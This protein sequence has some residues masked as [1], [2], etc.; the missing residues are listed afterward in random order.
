MATMSANHAP[1]GATAPEPV[2]TEPVPATPAPGAPMPEPVVEA[3]ETVAMDV[4]STS[5]TSG[6]GQVVDTIRA[7]VSKVLDAGARLGSLAWFYRRT[8]VLIFLAIVFLVLLI[9]VV[10][11]LRS[12]AVT[13]AW[14]EVGSTTSCGFDTRGA[15]RC[16]PRD[17]AIVPV[18]RHIPTRKALAALT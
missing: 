14:R 13:E 11:V 2:A 15:H 18:V 17:I 3:S 8:I 12:V 16:A 1:D 5:T 10:C 6:K 7:G 9:F 4:D